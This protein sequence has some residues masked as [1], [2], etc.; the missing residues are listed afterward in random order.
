M[1]VWTQTGSGSTGAGVGGLFKA[2]S[3]G[4]NIV[5]L[6]PRRAFAVEVVG[7]DTLYWSTVAG[8]IFRTVLSTQTTTPLVSGLRTP[9]A[10][11][12]DTANGKLYWVTSSSGNGSVQRSNLD[13]TEIEI[14]IQHPDI[15]GVASGITVDASGNRIFWSDRSNNRLWTAGLDGT[16]LMQLDVGMDLVD[17]TSVTFNPIDS[18]LYW[19]ETTSGTNQISRANS[20]GSM[21]EVIVPNRSWPR[22]IDFNKRTQ[23]LYWID[24][25]FGQG[26][27]AETVIRR[28]QL[29]GTQVEIGE[30]IWPPPTS[31]RKWASGSIDVSP[32]RTTWRTANFTGSTSFFALS[33]SFD[34]C[35]GK[36]AHHGQS[37]SDGLTPSFTRRHMSAISAMFR[38]EKRLP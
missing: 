5:R 28:S 21:S 17:P 11:S 3:D 36:A 9:T 38:M 14:L 34:M 31:C 25:G 8:E 35:F 26:G 15:T 37:T 7:P 22:G 29:D 6:S 30:G 24:T 19:T 1:I 12:V 20:D 10:L 4:S 13:G 23:E 33:S 32:K 27:D 2:N 16:G 18:K